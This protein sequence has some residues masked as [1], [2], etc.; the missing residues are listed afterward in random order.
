MNKREFVRNLYECVDNLDAQ[1]LKEFLSENISFKFSNFDELNGVSDVIASNENFFKSVKRM[2]HSITKIWEIEDD[3]ICHGI[4]NYTRH[5]DSMYSASYSTIL[6]VEDE[7]IVEY[8]I[9]ADV[10]GL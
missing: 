4:V 8:L 10:S 6:K 1:K 2:Q 9:F 7:K 3:I 5:N